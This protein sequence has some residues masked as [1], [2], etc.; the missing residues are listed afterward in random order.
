[1]EQEKTKRIVNRH[2][3]G[4][5]KEVGDYLKY[6]EVDIPQED[7]LIGEIEAMKENENRTILDVQTL[8]TEFY[9]EDN[10]KGK[11]YDYLYPKSY[12]SAFVNGA[13]YPHI[14]T[15]EEY[16]KKLAEKEEWYSSE[17]YLTEYYKEKDKLKLF[18]LNSTEKEYK[19]KVEELVEEKMCEYKKSLR[20]GFTYQEFIFAHKYTVKLREIKNEANV[21][22][23]ST[24]QIG[25]KDFEYRVNDDITVYIK[26]NFGYGTSSYFFCNLKYK[27][28]NIL[29]YSWTV[30]Y[31]YVEMMDFIRYTRRYSPKRIS[32]EEVFDFTV[33]TANMAKHEPQKFI[34]EWIVNEVEEMMKETRLYMSVPEKK[35]EDFLNIKNNP[36]I[37]SI[38]EVAEYAFRD[39]IRNC[40]DRDREEYKALPKE[41]VI[42]FKAE[43]ITGSLLLLDN[44]RK[45]TEI[46]AVLVPYIAEIEEM[47]LILQPEIE[48]HMNKISSDL[49]KLNIRLS[50]LVKK[51][52][53]LFTLLDNHKKKIERIREQANK[54]K[55]EKDKISKWKAE[56]N[57]EEKHPEY[58]ELKIKIKKLTEEKEMLEKDIYRRE[59]FLKILTKCKKRIANFVEI[60]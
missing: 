12:N 9:P 51:L 30:K 40:N 13:S 10:F 17:E 41:K 34:N 45:L 7:I 52:D 58:V 14:L 57:Y 53:P 8:L 37:F 21:K 2:F 39:V 22:M 31:F 15:I 11:H 32:W 27:D 24:D 43:K 33:E 6:E 19:A 25:W 49:K 59:N 23:Y 1:M 3:I 44:L 56:N 42:A 38:P 54:N 5:V 55:E 18:K 35:L 16:K 4:V 26:T 47:N 20:E 48:R 28:I 36:K 60:A 50:E 46:A 29:P